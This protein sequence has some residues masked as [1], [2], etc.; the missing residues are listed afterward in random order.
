M[1][2]HNYDNL[3][4]IIM[5]H[6]INNM[7]NAINILNDLPRDELLL[8]SLKICQ[9]IYNNK[10]DNEDYIK[11][12]DSNNSPKSSS[13]DK[14]SNNSSLIM[15]D[16]N[17]FYDSND[18]NDSNSNPQKN[19]NPFNTSSL[20]SDEYREIKTTTI[21]KKSK[22]SNGYPNLNNYTIIDKIGSGSYGKVYLARDSITDKLYAMKVII[23]P[24]DKL[25]NDNLVS[26]QREI[27]IMK[28]IRHKN[29]SSL[30]EV[31]DDKNENKIYIVIDYID[32][33]TI[34]KK[35]ENN[36]ERINSKKVKKYLYQL[37]AGLKYLHKHN[38]IH[39]DIKPDNILLDKN[40]NV[41]LVDFGVSEF[42][43]EKE[44]MT[45]LRTGTLLFFS[46][47]LFSNVKNLIGPP[48]DIWALGITLFA[49]LYGYLPFNGESF[50]EIKE[51]ITKKIP[52]F[53]EYA[54]PQQIDL[55]HK[56]LCKDPNKRITLEGIRQHP[57]M[58]KKITIK[59]KLSENKN[60]VIS[61]HEII[62]AFTRKISGDIYDD[63]NNNNN[64]FDE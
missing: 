1:D 32:N 17:D 16:S 58:K 43:C 49:M 12:I 61:E 64:S 6:N 22:D 57:F 35:K 33:G 9:E 55:L 60:I 20:R 42:L 8:L 45:K 28:K 7:N 30:Y 10:K 34:L 5:S 21:V 54:T 38:I 15:N 37:T 3:K 26:I 31:I 46:P 11:N 23:K 52:I 14:K 41:F 44:M 48:I 19:K 40:D 25:K 59:D 47:E 36:Y 50:C 53:P 13:S 39:R 2:I 51:N 62:N 24:T 56:I 4:K 18:Q 29:V 63:D 27:A